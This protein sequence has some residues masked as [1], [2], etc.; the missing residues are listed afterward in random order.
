MSEDEVAAAEAEVTSEAAT[1]AS[2]AV[3]VTSRVETVVE[4][5]VDAVKA[6]TAVVEAEF[7]KAEDIVE[8]WFAVKFPGSIVAASSEHW[9]FLT[10][11]KDELKLLLRS[12]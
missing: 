2:E 10:I 11:A 8:R 9:N 6:D 4:S 1:V 12:K 7:E 3:T 5:V